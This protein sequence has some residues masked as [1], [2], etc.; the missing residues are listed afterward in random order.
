M[1]EEDRGA[2]L[3]VEEVAR[4]L[5][6]EMGY[7]GY[8]SMELFSRTMADEGKH[9]PDEHAQ[10]GITAWRKLSERLLLQ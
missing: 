1:Y 5:I 10:R 7:K 3:P 6:H 4:V 9:V 2:Y 8:V